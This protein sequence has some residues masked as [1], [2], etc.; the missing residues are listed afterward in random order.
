MLT[1]RSESGLTYLMERELYE[2]EYRS[3]GF[4]E[5]VEPVKPTRA[6]KDKTDESVQ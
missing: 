6:K 4:V 2:V 5:V 1:V 3:K